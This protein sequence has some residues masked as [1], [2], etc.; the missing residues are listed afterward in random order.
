M[1][2]LISIIRLFI[3]NKYR[4]HIL[5]WRVILAFTEEL[6]LSEHLDS[7][8]TWGSGV[9]S[10]AAPTGLV[11]LAAP[12]WTIAED[13]HYKDI[14]DP[15]ENKAHIGARVIYEAGFLGDGTPVTYKRHVQY[16][17][18]GRNSAEKRSYLRSI[19]RDHPLWCEEIPPPKR[20]VPTA[21]GRKRSPD[22][23]GTSFN[24]DAEVTLIGEEN[25]NSIE[26]IDVADRQ[27]RVSWN[28]AKMLEFFVEGC[29][30]EERAVFFKEGGKGLKWSQNRN[31]VDGFER[32]FK[33]I[34]NMKK[35]NRGKNIAITDITVKDYPE[36][37]YRDIEGQFMLLRK[38]CDS[39][40]SKGFKLNPLASE[41]VPLAMKPK[42][43]SGV[44]HMKRPSRSHD[45]AAMLAWSMKRES[46][47]KIEELDKKI[48]KL[49][50]LHG[51]VVCAERIQ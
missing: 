29:S 35:E 9:P 39:K 23:A 4:I 46:D 40:V 41:F 43:P 18:Y 51:P 1:R 44:P 8:N 16:E 3:T 25:H 45:S 15:I 21:E 30:V 27:D 19:N 38:E 37:H 10:M 17:G 32:I 6:G 14:Y 48:Q 13:I 47:E 7:P 50:D 2:N 36:K 22:S 42:K 20:S 34:S 31:L 5:Y 49:I 33:W 12:R 11:R 26:S 28:F 24:T